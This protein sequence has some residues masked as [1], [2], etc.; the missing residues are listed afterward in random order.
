[1]IIIAIN[2]D[3]NNNLIEDSKYII[4]CAQIF[5]QK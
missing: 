4:F 3:F 1:M 2:F 5:F